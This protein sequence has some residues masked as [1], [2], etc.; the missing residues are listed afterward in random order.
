MYREDS[1]SEDEEYIYHSDSDDDH[2]H[3]PPRLSIDPILSDQLQS[4]PDYLVMTPI[5]EM[6]GNFDN[7]FANDS[8]TNG[9]HYQNQN[10]GGSF[11]SIQ[12]SGQTVDPFESLFAS[13]S[14]QIS[15]I[16]FVDSLS[17]SYNNGLS[18]YSHAPIDLPLHP[19]STFREDIQP[20]ELDPSDFFNFDNGKK[21]AEKE[22]NFQDFF[23]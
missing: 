17:N 1:E 15:E 11:C 5:D 8:S 20:N 19:A 13:S 22:L 12:N 7:L 10:F 18:D 9:V 3:D 6:E 21:E 16:P 14:T 4:Q 23:S 2:L